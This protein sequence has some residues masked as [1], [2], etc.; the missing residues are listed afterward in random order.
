MPGKNLTPMMRQYNQLKQQYK[1]KIL[2]FRMGDFYETFGEDAK[3]ASK[4]LNI[5]LTSRDKNDDPTPLAGFPHHAIDQYLP[6]LINAGYKVAIADQVEDPK[7]AKGIVRREVTRV[8]T[9]GTMTEG[10]KT[11]NENNYLCAIYKDKNTYGISI[12]D[13]STG[14]FRITE[15]NSLENVKDEI[16]RISPS[17]LLVDPKQDFS[18][19]SD[20]SIQTIEDLKIG[21]EK[22]K[23]ILCKHFGKKSL[24]SYGISNNKIAI[25]SA[26]LIIYYLA[27]T[28]KTD[29]NHISSISYYDLKGE[30][31][32]DMSTLR[33][34][35]IVSSQS[36]KGEKTSLLGILDQAQTSMGSRKIRR[37]ILHPLLEIKKL[38]E[39]QR[40]VEQ[41]F[42]NVSLLNNIREEMKKI[43]DLERISS[44]VGMNRANG[45]DL[46]ALSNSLTTVKEVVKL[47]VESKTLGQITKELKKFNSI[48]SEINK[49][50]SASI[51]NSPPNTI[52]EGHL[53]KDGYDK[54]I[55]KIRTETKDSK[56]WLENLEKTE[57]E[58]TKISSLKVRF[59]KVFGYFIEVTNSYKDKVPN[60]Y[61]RKQTLVNC[62]RYITPELKKKEEI[63]LNAQ[64]K[65]NVLEYEVF[66]TVRERIF[67][68]FE[69]IQEIADLIS[70][71]DAL[72]SFAYVANQNN[73]CRP[74]IIDF[75]KKDGLIEI[76]NGRHPIIENFSSE[77]FISNDL[78][79]GLKDNRLIILTGPNMS[80]K[81][82]YIRQIALIILLAQIGSYVP[83]SSAKISLSDRIFTRVGASDDL[84]A[85]R[86]TFLVE[87]DEA[88]NIINNATKYS[89]I[90]LDEVG[91][92][93]S[94]YDGVSIAWAIAEY[95]NQ[96]IQARC[97]FATHYHE[98]L[99]LE[100]EL[101]GITNFNVAVVEEGDEVIFLRKIEKGGTNK[102]YG[103]HVAKMA[104][105]P[106]EIINRANEI[107]SGFE[108]EDMFGVRSNQVKKGKERK[109]SIAALQNEENTNQLTF[110]DNNLM[111]NIPT[112][113]KELKELDLD[114]LT[115]LEAMIKLEKWK[116]RLT[117]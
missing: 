84:T 117:R 50:I 46:L 78:D 21:Y 8:V 14:E 83:A 29:L 49:L 77:E 55:D 105:L 47:L 5:T 38:E 68:Y 36:E 23:D 113:F 111:E 32:L 108:Q 51:S 116:K 11:E 56:E 42:S 45:R 79:M 48:T 76:K 63:I 30:M 9:P 35:D 75:G 102:S 101:T 19:L 20:Y 114:N 69:S 1:D 100:D 41:L 86:S 58:R 107:L 33:N 34:L 31:I 64:E 62:E 7:L 10:K 106:E 27:E 92:G 12:C 39:R 13:L 88:S 16:S 4:V 95:I 57:K 60:D 103:I 115:P 85:G 104:G 17:E 24:S 25:T 96:K 65:L 82:T 90:V 59:N 81:S 15:T 73:Y 6:K 97:L 26:G 91:R 112:I 52:T 71:I 18:F 40:K 43:S 72:Q 109:D 54:E 74:E 22:S 89:F 61:I 37:W 2:L 44:R 94:T 110:M 70:Q 93:T 53:I 66:Q 87:M 99:K 80:G 67:K 28:Q 3:T 98:L